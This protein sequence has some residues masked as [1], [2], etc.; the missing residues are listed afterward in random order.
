MD[1]GAWQATV[2]GDTKGQTRLSDFHFWYM[3]GTSQLT[4]QAG[5]MGTI[6]SPFTTEETEAQTL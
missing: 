3:L 6:S 2:H 5:A 4:S 1:R